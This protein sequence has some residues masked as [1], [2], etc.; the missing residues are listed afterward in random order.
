MANSNSINFASICQAV[1]DNANPSLQVNNAGMA[2]KEVYAMTDAQILTDLFGCD[3]VGAGFPAFALTLFAR[4][5]KRQ[6]HSPFDNPVMTQIEK[7]GQVHCYHAASSLIS[8]KA[9]LLS[10]K[11]DSDK[12]LASNF[13][14]MGIVYGAKCYTVAKACKHSMENVVVVPQSWK[15]MMAG[16]SYET[17]VVYL[18]D[19]WGRCLDF[20]AGLGDAAYAAKRYAESVKQASVVFSKVDATTFTLTIDKVN[21]IRI[22]KTGV[23][24][25]N[26]NRRFGSTIIDHAQQ[27]GV[28]E[29]RKEDQL[30][31]VNTYG[32]FIY[33]LMYLG[34]DSYKSPSKLFRKITEGMYIP[35]SSVAEACSGYQ[36]FDKTAQEKEKSS[37]ISAV[38]VLPVNLKTT[39]SGNVLA[40]DFSKDD[41]PSW[42]VVTVPGTLTAAAVL[43]KFNLAEMPGGFFVDGRDVLLRF[44]DIP[45]ES[46]STLLLKMFE[47]ADVNPLTCISEVF[48]Y[49]F[50]TVE[51]A[52][53]WLGLKC[54][55]I[56]SNKLAKAV[57]RTQMRLAMNGMPTNGESSCFNTQQNT[58]LGIKPSNGVVAIAACISFSHIL[59]AGISA[60]W[61]DK[62]QVETIVDHTQQ[63]TAGTELY[64]N[65]DSVLIT[66]NGF[67]ES[68]EGSWKVLTF[69]ELKPI[70]FGA[71]VAQ[72]PFQTSEGVGYTSILTLKEMDISKRFAYQ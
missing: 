28:V 69:D 18:D 12:D 17:N 66:R 16:N 52:L 62:N 32:A 43:G 20:N 65:L 53:R 3:F 70:E 27:H 23:W 46:R 45:E 63:D 26:R 29:V 33:A 55:L 21:V 4:L 1:T 50:R 15:P 54:G 59:A 67:T 57:K 71:V 34:A 36:D 41:L 48:T 7:A 56:L 19:A 39:K 22:D 44:K 30:T 37:L 24:D 60:F 13:K 58:Q 38:S 9:S 8:L 25:H 14:A 72:V 2:A 61:G 42:N 51:D 64:G 10:N 40:C 49:T 47:V 68:T 35:M 5:L 6:A 11:G 31:R